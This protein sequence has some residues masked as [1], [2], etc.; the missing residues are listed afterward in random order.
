MRYS[1]VSLIAV[2]LVLALAYG[3]AS[4]H[5]PDES[6]ALPATA[7]RCDASI[8]IQIELTPLNQPSV[9][10][11]TRF[12][13]SV[14]SSL[15]PDL[16]RDLQ[17]IYE[18]PARVRTI[19]QTRDASRVLQRSGQTDLEL[20]ILLPDEARYPVRARLVVHLANGRTISQTAVN[21]VGVSGE[22]RPEGMIGRIVDPD[23]T[24]IRVYRGETV[25]EP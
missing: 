25:R 19:P 21:W 14:M 1:R 2:V 10:R 7:T 23:G 6:E 12:R 3:A 22:D 15:D 4:R 5:A 11:P 17:V 8:P 20:G 13:V 18:L 24:G 9:G 16:V